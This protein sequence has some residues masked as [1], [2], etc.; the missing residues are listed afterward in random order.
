MQQR[1][2]RAYT[3]TKSQSRT[4]SGK[5]TP[6]TTESPGTTESEQG[7]RRVK[8]R[9]L[10]LLPRRHRRRASD[11]TGDEQLADHRGD[12]GA[13]RCGSRRG[14]TT[15]RCGSRRVPQLLRVAARRVDADHG[16]T[17]DA[18]RG[19][20]VF[21]LCERWKGEGGSGFLWRSR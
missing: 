9:G 2:P 14:T 15:S 12:G 3:T 5:P 21:G 19:S 20:V 17:G 11:G 16:A 1:N 18:G 4:Q 13:C 10:T 6:R 8:G 7:R